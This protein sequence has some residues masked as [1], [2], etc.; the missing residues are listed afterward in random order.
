MWTYEDNVPYAEGRA[1][2]LLEFFGAQ[3]HGLDH[4]GKSDY[5]FRGEGRAGCICAIP[6]P[7]HH[8]AVCSFLG[9]AVT[10][11]QSQLKSA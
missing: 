11:E 8:V 1:A 5:A 2:Q 10:M 7:V 6:K 9:A 4:P 3:I